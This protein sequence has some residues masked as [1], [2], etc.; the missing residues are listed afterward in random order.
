MSISAVQLRRLARRA[1]APP[2]TI[3]KQCNDRRVGWFSISS[4]FCFPQRGIT[5]RPCASSPKTPSSQPRMTHRKRSQMYCP[6]ESQISGRLDRKTWRLFTDDSRRSLWIENVVEAGWRLISSLYKHCISF[7]DTSIGNR[8]QGQIGLALGVFDLCTTPFG[9]FRSWMNTTVVFV[10]SIRATCAATSVHSRHE[11][12][13]LSTRSTSSLLSFVH[14]STLI[15]H[16]NIPA[17]RSKSTHAAPRKAL[18]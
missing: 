12:E 1:K 7:I 18:Q 14:A 6:T 4:H 9:N 8:V 13:V 17:D 3:P 10:A 16:D 11:S 5:R 15:L 2:T